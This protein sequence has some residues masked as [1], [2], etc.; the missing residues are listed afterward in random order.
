MSVTSP[1]IGQRLKHELW[2]FA[3]LS[4]Y[5][6]VCFGA[7]ILYKMAILNGEGVSYLPFGLVAIKALILGKF[8]LLGQ[9]VRL[10]GGH[11]TRRIAYLIAYKALLYLVLLI[12]LSVIEEVVVGIIHGQEAAASLAEHAGAKLPQTLAAS[13]IMLLILIPYLASRE[14]DVALGEGRL[15]KMLFEHRAGLPSGGSAE[16][17]GL[18]NS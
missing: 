4:A 15:W 9:A 6:Y 2:E 14:L 18:R 17:R 16:A 10:G 11:E 13:L 3:L 7:L 12:A 5:L 1:S 8:I